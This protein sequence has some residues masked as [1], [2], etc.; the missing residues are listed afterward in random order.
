MDGVMQ[1]NC[2]S[3]ALVLHEG[4]RR[5]VHSIHDLPIVVFHTVVLGSLLDV[6]Q[7]QTFRLLPAGKLYTWGLVADKM[8]RSVGC[9]VVNIKVDITPATPDWHTRDDVGRMREAD[10]PY[11]TAQIATEILVADTR[12]AER[13]D[14]R[15][16]T[17]YDCGLERCDLSH[18]A[19]QR[20]TSEHKFFVRSGLHEWR[21]N[22]DDGQKRPD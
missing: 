3:R 13:V 20:M 12:R 1:L 19:P 2:V 21:E 11:E 10:M 16:Y 8:D 15:I 18:G 7:H 9:V 22:W 6:V 17:E 4:G 14:P 5:N